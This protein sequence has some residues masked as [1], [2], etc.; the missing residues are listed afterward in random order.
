[1]KPFNYF[2][3]TE[4]RF[5]RGRLR[6]LGKAAVRYGT[7]AL[8]VTVPATETLGPVIAKARA[9]LEAAGLAVSHFEGVVPNPTTDSIAAGSAVAREHQADLVVGVGGGSSLDTAKAIAV[10]VT[11]AGTCWDYLFDKAA[12]S[13]RTLPVIAVTT[14]S[15]TGSHVTQVAV[16][17]NTPLRT[18]SYLCDRQ[19]FP[20]LAIV[21]PE[22]MV[23]APRQVT[24]M[25]GW[26]AWT[27]AFEAYLHKACSPYV[28]MLAL[29]AIRLVA[30][31]LPPL[32]EDL[33]NLEL[34][35]AMAWADTLAGL[36]I[37]NAGVTLPHSV[38]M[39]ISGRWP[40]VA[41][42]ASLA[43]VYP[44]FT[45]YTAAAAVPQFAAVGRILNPELATASDA[46][47]AAQCCVEMDLLLQRIGL[48][49]DLDGLGVPASEF[50]ALADQSLQ[51][52]DYR[53]NPRT[54]TRDEIRALLDQCRVR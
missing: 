54:P 12:P 24:A 42:G 8:L 4:I 20:R 1:M 34:R 7:R 21:D 33:D 19:L 25:T 6:Q 39:A 32:L 41:H 16:A 40:A 51:L 10:Q 17:T 52:P 36:C 29:E 18:K 22:L 46:D 15:G 50:D 48:W 37:A 13:D 23:T 9:S 53:N 38:G 3:P 27:H 35:T 47:A 5:G 26:D 14:T 43:V 30:A 28:A 31:N 11:H 2:Q 45:R 49:I 44:A